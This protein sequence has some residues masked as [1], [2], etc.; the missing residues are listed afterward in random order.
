ML[1]TF[2]MVRAD[3]QD[4]QRND[5]ELCAVARTLRRCGVKEPT[6]YFE[7]G[8]CVIRGWYGEER[9]TRFAAQAVED[10]IRRFD[11]DLWVEPITFILDLPDNG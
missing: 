7:W 2:E 9:F 4:A 6:V 3:I 5:A 8:E 11:E 10:F 1:V